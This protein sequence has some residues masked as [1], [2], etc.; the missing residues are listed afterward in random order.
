MRIQD[1]NFVKG[2]QKLPVSLCQYF[3]RKTVLNCVRMNEAKV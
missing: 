1:K 3:V 2:I